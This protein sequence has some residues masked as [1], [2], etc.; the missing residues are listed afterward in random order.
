MCAGLCILKTNQWLWCQH[1]YHFSPGN[2]FLASG[3][4]LLGVSNSYKATAVWIRFPR[5]VCHISGFHWN[6]TSVSFLTF[7]LFWSPEHFYNWIMGFA[8]EC[9]ATLPKPQRPN[10]FPFGF[11]QNNKDSSK[12]ASLFKPW[13]M[14]ID[15][16]KKKGLLFLF[17]IW[18]ASLTFRYLHMGIKVK[19][20]TANSMFCCYVG[21]Y[22]GFIWGWGGVIQESTFLRNCCFQLY[23]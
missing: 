6:T 12:F 9:K 14:F 7:E 1:V 4:D 15:Y 13:S 16:I 8:G 17:C 21:F 23:F 11:L 5:K 19:D 3:F 18:S 2:I 22:L 10:F 20:S